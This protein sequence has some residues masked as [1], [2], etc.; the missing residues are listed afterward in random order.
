M[1]SK[2]SNDEKKVIEQQ[3]F[4][5][6]T[7]IRESDIFLIYGHNEIDHQNIPTDKPGPQ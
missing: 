6:S 1:P 2:K 3:L 5:S 4:L 7:V